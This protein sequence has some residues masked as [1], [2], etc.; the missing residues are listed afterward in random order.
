[1]GKLMFQAPTDLQKATNTRLA[2]C[3]YYTYFT[4][5]FASSNAVPSVAMWRRTLSEFSRKMNFMI[6]EIST[7]NEKKTKQNKFLYSCE[8][9][10]IGTK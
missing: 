4:S 9:R 3:V 6:K 10:N 1:M 2:G 5:E 7:T 8:L